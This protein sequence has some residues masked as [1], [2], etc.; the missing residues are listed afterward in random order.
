MTFRLP[1]GTSQAW[2][3]AA[4]AFPKREIL[5]VQG[6]S[7]GAWVG[8]SL[9]ESHEAVFRLMEPGGRELFRSRPA[10]LRPG[11]SEM[12]IPFP[13]VPGSGYELRMDTPTSRRLVRFVAGAGV[14]S[15]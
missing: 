1:A 9:L 5:A 14:T 12:R 15:R 3:V 2:A 6:D 11:A 4:E 10:S 8:I 13:L 7:A